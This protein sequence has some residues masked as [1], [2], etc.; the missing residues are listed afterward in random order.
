MKTAGWTLAIL[1]C[2]WSAG[3]EAPPQSCVVCHSTMEGNLAEPVKLFPGDVHSQAGL[4]C[5]DCHG[6]NPND[7]TMD[8]MSPA[9]GFR[10]VP[11]K[12]QIPE[13]CGRCHS[14]A[15][16]MRQFNPKVRTDVWSEYLTSLHGKRLK[17][18]DVNVATCVDCHGVHT[19]L[20]VSDS[21]A[22]VYPTNVPNTC[23]RCHSDAERMKD[24][25]IPTDQAAKY[26][27]S[28][29]AKAM[30]AGDLSAPT[31]S[32]CHGSHGATPPGVDS[33]GNVCGTCHV[34]FAQVFDKSP[35]KAVFASLELP[36]CVQ[37]HS[38]HAIVAPQDDFVGVS[39][40]SV[41]V[42]C[43]AEGDAGYQV[44]KGISENL[45]G[46]VSA[47]DRAESSLSAAERSGM[48]VSTARLA[49]ANASE[50]LIK[51]RVSVHAFSVS[52]VKKL[53][54]EGV[55]IAKKADEAGIAALRERDF[56][57]K[58]LG[59]SL[60]FIVLAIVGLYLKIRQMESSP[61]S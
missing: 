9:K 2:A 25:K 54:D 31:C 12:A 51:A 34:F 48:E 8:S 39:S 17:Q 11:K 28:V 42:G 3:A 26:K 58:G 20:S 6:G 21:R 43:H 23:G 13:F 50:D 24:Y 1:L 36:G 29:H 30:A 53:T 5:A 49:L 45:S 40:K 55:G 14:D 57:R 56:R 27:S 41:C 32:T 44:A 35:H 16:Y 33:V 47:I 10:G 61:E 4:G 19:T 46:L 7:D 38:N 59:F 15:N 22:P 37:C 18:G 60:I 52:E